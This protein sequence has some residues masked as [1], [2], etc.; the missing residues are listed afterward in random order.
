MDVFDAA[1]RYQKEGRSLIILAGRDYGS[2][3]RCCPITA[4]PLM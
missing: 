4:W 3:K 1:E 2:G